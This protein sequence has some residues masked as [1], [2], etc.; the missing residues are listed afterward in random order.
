LY[1]HSATILTPS[2]TIV[3]GAVLIE[4]NRFAAVGLRAQVKPPSGARVIDAA[5]LWLVPG[6]I[7]LQLNGAF[8]HDFTAAPDTLWDVAACL[9]HYGVTAFLPTIVT[10]PW[11]TITAA[12]AVLRKGAPPGFAGAA[13]L[14]LHLE[15]P[16]LNPEKRGAHDP[17]Y[18]RPPASDAIADWSLPHGIRLVTLAPELPGAL[19]MVRALAARGVVVS[20]GHSRAS[21]AEACAGLDAGIRYSTHLFNAMPPMDHRAPGLVGALLTDARVT[22]GLIPDGVHLHASVVALAWQAKGPHQVNLVTDAIAALGAPPGRYRLGDFEVLTDGISARLADGR[23]AGSVLS[24][25]QAVRNL[26]AFTGCSLAEAIGTVTATP[27]ALLGLLHERGRIAPGL[28]ADL[29]LLSPDLH[30]TATIVQGQE[31]Y[32]MPGDQAAIKEVKHGTA[33][34]DF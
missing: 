9:P 22:V 34:R 28:L 33:Q 2:Q 10:S 4:G 26:I 18:L 11:E 15:G 24:L 30:V 21:Y 25:D 1:I 27:A 19:D 14:G 20:A 12:Q 31:V 32:S 23:L 3:D 29:T 7:D 13:P 8:G 17:A 16:F 5:G 6:L